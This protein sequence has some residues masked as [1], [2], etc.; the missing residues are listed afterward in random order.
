L[1][2]GPTGIIGFRL[3]VAVDEAGERPTGVEFVLRC[4]FFGAESFDAVVVSRAVLSL[5][6][7]SID[8]LPLA[9][10]EW[11]VARWVSFRDIERGEREGRGNFDVEGGRRQVDDPLAATESSDFVLDGRG[12][13]LVVNERVSDVSF[14]VDVAVDFGFDVVFQL[15]CFA[16]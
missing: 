15:P 6:D 10:V 16:G 2:G 11:N 1:N 7:L 4:E 8:A 12:V 5:V 9:G 13:F 14:R 3:A